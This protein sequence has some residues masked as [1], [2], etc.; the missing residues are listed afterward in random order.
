[1]SES[2]PLSV[3][4]KWKEEWDKA[5]TKGP[6]TLE[7]KGGPEDIQR[8]KLLAAWLAPGDDREIGNRLE[9]DPLPGGE[10]SMIRLVQLLPGKDWDPIEVTL[11]VAKLEAEFEALSYCWGDA[12]MRSPITCNGCQ[13]D[14]TR[15]LKSA[16]RDLRRHDAPRILWIDAI[17]INQN[18]IEEREQQLRIMADVFRSA[19][20]TVVWLGETFTKNAVA[21]KLLKRMDEVRRQMIADGTFDTSKL[22][23]R[24][25]RLVKQ[26]PATDPTEEEVIALYALLKRPWFRRAWVI[27]EVSLAKEVL[28]TCGD[29]ELDWESFHSGV[30]CVGLITI[31]QVYGRTELYHS[32]YSMHDVRS[33]F[34]SE[35]T[36]HE[37]LP[38]LNDFRHFLATDPRDKVFALIGVSNIDPDRTNLAPDYRSS[39][40]EIYVRLAKAILGS[41]DKLDILSSAGGCAGLSEALPSWVPDVSNTMF[42][43]LLIPQYLRA[44][45][46][47]LGLLVALL[48]LSA[49]FWDN[50][51]LP[52]I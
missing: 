2:R 13:L 29:Q 22:I 11:S 31:H 25:E 28:I 8:K 48:N 46:H 12:A 52:V 5:T 35:H 50:T 7:G 43:M 40:E 1:M 4:N 27:Q 30:K 36:G 26:D 19:V 6:E 21:F 47:V 45:S 18:D 16:L 24:V 23:W 9:Y 42:I 37:L 10:E 49:H 39:P 17:C 32:V 41:H 51:H 20:R 38:L 33:H 34:E 44:V 15:N 3:F 14:V